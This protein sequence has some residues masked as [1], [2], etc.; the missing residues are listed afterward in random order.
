MTYILYVYVGSSDKKEENQT[1][2]DPDEMS[3]LYE[4]ATMSID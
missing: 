2:E 3:N 1:D 4:E